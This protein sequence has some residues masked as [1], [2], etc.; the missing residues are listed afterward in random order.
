[1]NQ[2]WIQTQAYYLANIKDIKFYVEVFFIDQQLAKAHVDQAMYIINEMDRV[3]SKDCK[4]N[5][6]HRLKKPT[7]FD[8]KWSPPK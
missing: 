4:C 6:S 2:D 3:N 5:S 1:M 7:Q 8:S